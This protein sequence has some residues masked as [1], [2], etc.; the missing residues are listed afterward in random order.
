[1][2]DPLTTSDPADT[3]RP[4]FTFRLYLTASTLPLAPAQRVV[5]LNDPDRL[6][7]LASLYPGAAFWGRAAF[8]K[9][10]QSLE[11]DLPAAARACTR[12]AHA[13]AEEAQP[14]GSTTEI[15]KEPPP[16][17]LADDI[18]AIKNAQADN[19]RLLASIN[20]LKIEFGPAAVGLVTGDPM[21]W[22]RR[23]GAVPPSAPG[24]AD[25]PAP[26]TSEGQAAGA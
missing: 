8:W 18:L 15:P 20:N 19:R 11:Q 10:V 24:P 4:A 7:D 6:R 9:F 26:A 12:S 22:Y 3:S 25:G 2:P 5:V 13:A 1:M 23:I 21:E 17:G 14:P 16:E